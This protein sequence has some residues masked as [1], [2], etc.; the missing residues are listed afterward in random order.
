[1]IMFNQT[2]NLLINWD[3]VLM[4]QFG[5][6][7]QGHSLIIFLISHD[8]IKCYIKIIFSIRKLFCLLIKKTLI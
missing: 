7:L 6:D 5:L 1:M 8:L 3:W 2:P 4:N